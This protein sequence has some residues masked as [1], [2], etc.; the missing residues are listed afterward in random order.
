M[1]TP[2]SS[3]GVVR[4]AASQPP[5][6]TAPAVSFRAR[7]A[8]AALGNSV[9][10]WGGAPSLGRQVIQAA[11]ANAPGGGLAGAMAAQYGP[12]PE[13]ELAGMLRVQMALHQESQWFTTMSNAH[14]ALSTKPICDNLK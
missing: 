1:S 13:A 5:A 14:K 8:S 9:P 2:I 7:L 11:T 4:P 3:L 12:A 10:A 6:R